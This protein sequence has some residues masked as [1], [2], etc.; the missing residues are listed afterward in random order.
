MF[1]KRSTATILRHWQNELD[2][3]LEIGQSPLFDLGYTNQTLLSLLSVWM[4]PAVHTMGSHL[5]QPIAILGGNDG[6]WLIADYLA[7]TG[8]KRDGRKTLSLIFAGADPATHYASLATHAPPHA[9]W[10]VTTGQRQTNLPYQFAVLFAPISQP[11]TAASWD[12]FP[13][14]NMST[15]A[16]HED[17]R[18]EP[19]AAIQQSRDSVDWTAWATLLFCSLL[20][21]VALIRYAV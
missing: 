18:Q 9:T 1:W 10:P 15:R 5:V 20:I 3:S 12:A 19:V 4:L 11:E 21:L 14:A 17:G 6:S 16:I 7:A 13:W 2:T 8:V